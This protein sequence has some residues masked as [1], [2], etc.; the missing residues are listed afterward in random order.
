[1][2]LPGA[3][4][5]APTAR[6]SAPS[7]SVATASTGTQNHVADSMADYI[8]AHVSDEA[9]RA[10]LLGLY[11]EKKGSH[12][13]AATGEE[14]EASLQGITMDTIMSLLE[15]GSKP[16]KVQPAAKARDIKLLADLEEYLGAA[17]EAMEEDLPLS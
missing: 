7:T 5:T 13:I 2:I 1:M 15:E 10:R 6:F 9:V 17:G 3:S 16:A 4:A 12:A 14:S 8:A 11:A